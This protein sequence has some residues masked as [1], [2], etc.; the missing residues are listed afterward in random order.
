MNSQ[1]PEIT[2]FIINNF[3]SALEKDV[4][5]DT[6]LLNEGVV[7]S[8]GLLTIISYV[9]ELTNTAVADEDVT[10]E[11]FGTIRSLNEFVLRSL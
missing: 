10:P 4:N 2:R 9:E 1:I 7:D 5:E 8:L 3:P 6:D 11:N